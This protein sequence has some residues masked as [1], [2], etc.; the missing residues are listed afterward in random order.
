MKKVFYNLSQIIELSDNDSEFIK[1]MV[2]TFITEMSSDLDALAVAVLEEDRANVHGYAQKMKP[3]LELFGLKGHHMA[4]KL[5]YWGGSQ[6]EKDI[7]EDFMYLHQELEETL[8]QLRRD[9]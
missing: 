4:L 1:L 5:E 9:F 6:E 8:I 7:H 3:S 2:A